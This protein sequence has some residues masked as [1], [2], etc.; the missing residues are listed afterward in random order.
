MSNIQDKSE[1]IKQLAKNLPGQVVLVLQGGGALGSYQAGVYQALHE[2]GIEPDWIIGTS[3]G[4]I[5]ASLI[6]GNEIEDRVARLREFWKRMEQKPIWNFAEVLPGFDEKFSYWST[7]THGMLA[8]SGPILSLTQA[9]PLCWGRTAP[10]T[11]RPHRCNGRWRNWSTSISSAA[12]RPAS[13]SAQLMCAPAR[14]GTST[15]A[16]ASSASSM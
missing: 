13:P 14:C 16:T 1:R 7:I 9:T 4:A 11:T 2:A 15:A 10:A 6:A 3:I 5:N 12:A 8:S